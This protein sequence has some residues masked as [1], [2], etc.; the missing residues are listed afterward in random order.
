MRRHQLIVAA[1]EAIGEAARSYNE[2]TADAAAQLAEYESVLSEQNTHYFDLQQQLVESEL[3]LAEEGEQHRQLL[4]VMQ[5]AVRHAED[6]V[7]KG[8]VA[9]LVN[10]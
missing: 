3:Q 9:P 10:R 4:T 8:K 5:K 2:H 6:R 7:G 1:K